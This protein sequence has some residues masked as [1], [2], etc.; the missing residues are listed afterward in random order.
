[1]PFNASA[2]SVALPRGSLI[3]VTGVT[4]YIAT[5]IVVET[6]SAGYKVRGTARTAEKA[7]GDEA[8]HSTP[9]YHC[10]VVEDSLAPGAFD[11][12]L[13]G[14]DGIIH[15]AM[16]TDMKPDPNEVIPALVN[17]LT[18]LLESC[19]RIPTIKRFV[20]M[21]SA[22]AATLPVPG[23]PGHLDK[24]TWNDEAVKLAWTPPHPPEKAIQCMVR[25]KWK[26]KRP[27]GNGWKRKNRSL[28]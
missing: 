3:L 14:I 6:L 5:H 13:D 25:A 26:L 9:D 2:G 7:K 16:P 1:M 18:S 8:F 24:N 22:T 28:L 17:H 27:C 19:S 23:R 11:E 20:Y 12:A 4:G 10:V 21:S 15:V